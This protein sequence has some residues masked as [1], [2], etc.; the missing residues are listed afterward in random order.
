MLRLCAC[1]GIEA[2]IVEPAGFPM[3]DR[4]FRRAGMDYLDAVTHRAACAHGRDFDAWRRS[5]GRRLVLFTTGASACP[6]SITATRPDDILL[7]GRESAGVPQD[8]HAAADARLAI[9]MRHG[10]ALAQC[11]GCRRHGRRRSAAADRQHMPSCKSRVAI[12]SKD[13]GAGPAARARPP[14]RRGVRLPPRRSSASKCRPSDREHRRRRACALACA[15]VRD[16]RRHSRAAGFRRNGC[17]GCPA[18]ACA[19]RS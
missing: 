5:Q 9:P 12:A 18:S 2:H 17:A 11:R 10:L 14:P 4:A 1:L 16:R 19:I 8:V 13:D 15:R 6:I 3:S 7:F